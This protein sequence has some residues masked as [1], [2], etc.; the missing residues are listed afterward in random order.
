MLQPGGLQ[1]LNILAEA[2][3]DVKYGRTAPVRETFGDLRDLLSEE[4]R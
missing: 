2:E 4:L 3:E 1:W